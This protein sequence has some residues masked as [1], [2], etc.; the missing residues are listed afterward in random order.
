MHHWSFKVS[1]IY[2]VSMQLVCRNNSLKVAFQP[3]VVEVCPTSSGFHVLTLTSAK[4][5]KCLPLSSDLSSIK[6]QNE[7]SKHSLDKYRGYDV[8][9][10]PMADTYASGFVEIA[11]DGVELLFSILSYF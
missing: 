2:K 8:D 4:K 7:L 9:L 3:E 1:W 10:N 5:I 11:G 6:D